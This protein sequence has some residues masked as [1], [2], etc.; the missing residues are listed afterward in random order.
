MELP[1]AVHDIIFSFEENQERAITRNIPLSSASTFSVSVSPGEITILPPPEFGPVILAAGLH[2][3]TRL[4]LDQ[5]NVYWI[6][7]KKK[8]SR[9]GGTPT[10]LATQALVGEATGIA[11]DDAF[12]YW[13][14]TPGGGNGFIY[15]APLTGGTPTF[16]AF[17]NQPS[18]MAID[19]SFVYWTENNSG[20]DSTQGVR[21][22]ALG[23]GDVLTATTLGFP[24]ALNLDGTFVYF[25][26]TDAI[27]GKSYL[28]QVDKDGGSVT[29]LAVMEERASALVIDGSTIYWAEFGPGTV[30]KMPLTGGSVTTLA[31][32][33][34]QPARI[35]VEGTDVYVIEFANAVAGA[36]SIKKFSLSGG[37]IATLV[38]GLN[39]PTDITLDS[40]HIYWTELG[41]DGTDGSVKKMQK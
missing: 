1:S 20:P 38:D 16:L 27:D 17:A 31:S 28:G 36:G 13:S 4:T 11:V 40:T 18:D 25:S 29:P 24:L 22:V 26:Y 21:K 32:G 6:E 23:G 33:L 5:N 30:K 41:T 7:S 8:L 34:N 15:K 2:T 14:I 35:A 19:E 12:V 37:G 9:G 10:T 39:G 3:P